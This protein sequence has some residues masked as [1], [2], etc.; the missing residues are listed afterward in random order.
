MSDSRSNSAKK[1]NYRVVPTKSFLKDLR[2]LDK[3]SNRRVIEAAELLNSDPYLGKALR[4]PLEGLRSLRVGTLRVIY[5]VEDDART[6]TLHAA[7][8]RRS[9]YG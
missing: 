1:G 9:V 5:S 3:V 4:G 7:R 2:K 6:V 8:H